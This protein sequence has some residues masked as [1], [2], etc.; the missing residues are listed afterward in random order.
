M[1][2]EALRMFRVFY[3]LKQ[4]ELAEKLGVSQ[5]YISEIE[6]ELKSPSLD[7]IEKYSREIKIPVSSI[8]FFAEELPQARAGDRIRPKIANKV[9]Q[10]LRF[11]E[12]R[13]DAESVS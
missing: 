4:Y 1:I 9:I 11:V 5:S 13:A 6:K 10:L 7:L 8:M 12:R 3:D 2:N